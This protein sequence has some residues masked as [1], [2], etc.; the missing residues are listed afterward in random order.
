[1]PRR[2]TSKDS[3][4]AIEVPIL[5][6]ANLAFARGAPGDHA[7]LAVVAVGSDE[8]SLAGEYWSTG[9][10]RFLETGEVKWLEPLR[11]RP[12]GGCRL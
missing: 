6:P 5:T 2:Q 8:A 10:T 11:A 7:E 1:M 12:S 3:S 9:Y 4:R